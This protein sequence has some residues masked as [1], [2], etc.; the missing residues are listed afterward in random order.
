MKITYIYH[1]GFLAETSD[2]Y[3]L[4]DYYKG[5]LPH[6]DPQKPVLVFVSHRHP[7]HF[8]REV[9][10]LLREKGMAQVTAVLA[11]DIPP[12]AY[13]E[14]VDVIRAV[15]HQTYPLPCQT[16]LQT[17]LS[18]DQG[19]AFLVQSDQCTLYHGGDLNDWSMENAS[20]QDNK[21]TAGS[22]RHEINLLREMLGD[23]PLDA[24]FLPLDPRQG[25]YFDRGMLYFL[26]KIPVKTVY[27]MHY[28]DQPEI[29]GQFLQRH[30]QYLSTL[31]R[32]DS[33]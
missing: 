11:K 23:K 26:E 14:G 27:P 7:D 16:T 4:F 12:K 25:E 5:G 13:P 17:L 28:W 1:S 2:C 30:P 20:E 22:Y 32:P 33:H 8:N 18:T 9:F 24:A 21:H 10:S 3:Y 31:R 29:I 6:L 15:H 19:V